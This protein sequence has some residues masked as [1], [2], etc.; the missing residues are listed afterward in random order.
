[1][2]ASVLLV[3]S[4]VSG[5]CIGPGHDV[6]QFFTGHVVSTKP[7]ASAL[8]GV[9]AVSVDRRQGVKTPGSVTLLLNGDG[10]LSIAGDATRIFEFANGSGKGTWA[11]QQL[12]ADRVWGVNIVVDHTAN[13]SSFE[14]WYVLQK[15]DGTYE[16]G[17]FY[18]DPDSGYIVE[19][20]RVATPTTAPN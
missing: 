3:I 11:L 4:F 20:K 10:T 16:L 2:R 5:C 7:A 18:D 13:E 8:V 9:Y 14:S 17:Q 6:R 1:M 12:D 19:L 15:N